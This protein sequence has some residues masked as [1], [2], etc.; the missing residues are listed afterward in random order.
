[1]KILGSVAAAVRVWLAC[2]RFD[3]DA[4]SPV[5]FPSGRPSGVEFSRFDGSAHAAAAVEWPRW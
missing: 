5:E 2:T 3:S 4:Y 1:M